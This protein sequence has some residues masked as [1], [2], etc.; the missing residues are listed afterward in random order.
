MSIKEIVKFINTKTTQKDKRIYMSI[1]YLNKYIMK[2]TLF[3]DMNMRGYDASNFTDSNLFEIFQTRTKFPMKN[4][5]NIKLFI[6]NKIEILSMIE[7]KKKS[8]NPDYKTTDNLLEIMKKNYSILKIFELMKEENKKDIDLFIKFLD[9]QSFNVEDIF[10]IFTQINMP[11]K[12]LNDFFTP[13]D[14]SNILGGIAAH[15]IKNKDKKHI[16]ICD[17]ACGSGNLLFSTYKNI[18]KN[19]EDMK[20][21]VFGNDIDPFYAAFTNSIFSLFNFNKTFIENKNTLTEDLFK[22]MGFDIQIGNPPFGSIKKD[23]YEKI[24]LNTPDNRLTKQQLKLKK[25]LQNSDKD[26]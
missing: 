1:I 5:E 17:I 4:Q 25:K 7:T 3:K 8:L 11:D 19:N 16:S 20:I 22:G 6:D 2:D 23:D 9:T 18:R 24:I 15:G 14:I 12:N 13:M 10:K 21:L 26:D